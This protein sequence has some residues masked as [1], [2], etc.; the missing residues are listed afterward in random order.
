MKRIVGVSSLVLVWL[1]VGLGCKKEDSSQGA[2]APTASVPGGYP[3]GYGTGYPPGYAT[4]YPPG[5]GYPPPT[6]YPTGYP[7]GP[8]P[9]G[10]PTGPAP[11]GAPAA[12]M[13][14]PGPM[15][16][17]CTSNA[18][19]GLAQCNTQYGKCAFPCQNSEV[20]CIQGAQCNTLTGFCIPK[21]G[22]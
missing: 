12:T 7:T 20:D 1:A 11:T 6:A 3:P 15:A 5:T 21:T 4:G 2:A 14:V 16:F 17:P 8:A 22:P 18:N 10:Y 19:C 9:T 13:A